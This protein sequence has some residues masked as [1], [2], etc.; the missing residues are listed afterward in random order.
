MVCLPATL[1]ICLYYLN[2]LFEEI[3]GKYD[4]DSIAKSIQG[5]VSVDII[6]FV[7]GKRFSYEVG[8]LV[9]E[10]NNYN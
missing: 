6:R 2:I 8:G 5:S 1:W 3:T 10:E 4:N 7:V 9:L